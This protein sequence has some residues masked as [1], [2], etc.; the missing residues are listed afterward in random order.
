MELEI[1]L[2]FPTYI[3]LFHIG[4]QSIDDKEHFLSL[5]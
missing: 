4:T 5:V 1:H 3:W 2:W